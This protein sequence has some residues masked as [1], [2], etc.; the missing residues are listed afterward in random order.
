MRRRNRSTRINLRSR[1]G[2]RGLYALEFALMMLVF[3][4]LMLASWEIC[5]LALANRILAGT[6]HDAALAAGRDPANCLQ[7]A[8]NAFSD[9]RIAMWLFDHNNDDSLGFVAGADPDN[10]VLSELRLDINADDPAVDGIAFDQALC[11]GSGSW[12]RVRTVVRPR[13]WSSWLA[14]TTLRHESWS[15]NQT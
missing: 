12:I 13:G 7:A 1:R 15:V 5:R 6:T 4:P 11:G 9:D 14:D 2:M 10:T 8:R 3:V